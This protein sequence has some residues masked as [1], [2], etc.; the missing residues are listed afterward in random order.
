MV[1][2]DVAPRVS[3]LLPLWVLPCVVIV[4]LVVFW[5]TWRPLGGRFPSLHRDVAVLGGLLLANLLFFWRPLL[6]SAQVPR[7]GGDLNSYFFPLQAVSA[8]AIQTGQFPLWNPHLFGGMPQLA[9]YQ[10]AML[11]PPNLM[12]WMLHRPYTYGTLELLAISQYLIASVGAYFLAR[13]LGMERFPSTTAAIVFSACGFLTAHLGHYSML[14]VAVW[15]PFLFLVLRATALTDSLLWASASALVIFMAATGGHQQMLLY[16]LTAGGIWWIYWIGTRYQLWPWEGDGQ[17]FAQTVLRARAGIR[18]LAFAIS[19]AG[20]ALAVGLGLAAPMIVP[21]LQLAALSVRSGLSYEQATEFSAEPVALLQFLLPKAFG[22][23][24]TDYWGPFS[25]GEIWGYVGIVTL[26]LAAIALATRPTGVRLVLAAFAAVALL[27][28]LGPFTPLHGW[29]FRFV[30]PYNLIRAPARG[31]LF[32][33]LALALL[34][35]FG[36]SEIGYSVAQ[37]PH[38]RD[39][40]R[41]ATRGIALILGAL[42]LFVIPLFYSLILGVNDPSNRPVIAVDGL[43]L[44][45]VY[46]SGTLVLL[47]AVSRGRIRGATVVLLATVLIVLDLYGATA[48]F[49]PGS[50]DLTASYRHV[51]AVAF[52]QQQARAHGPFRIASTTLAWQPDLASIAGLDDAGGLFDP[53]QPASYKKVYD[54]MSR[55]TNP[56]LYDLLNVRYVITD[57][58]A[59]APSSSF[60]QVLKTDGGLILW[61]NQNVM[62]RAWLSYGAQQSTKAA[63]LSAVTT[64][65]FDPVSTL[66]VSGQLHPAESGGSGSARIDSYQNDRVSIHVQTDRRAYLVLADTAYP[67]WVATVDGTDT[68]IATADGIL[69]AV[70]VPAGTHEVVFRFNPPIVTVSWILSLV[71]LLILVGVATIG[72]FRRYAGRHQSSVSHARGD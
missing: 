4:W 39:V 64:P 33:D 28:A 11:Y 22:S 42:I 30:P 16:E 41:R 12:A 57:S 14:S 63:A 61:E 36:L 1:T 67:G 55:G 34:A 27:F 6:S 32:V 35:G 51:Q 13:S 18:P 29:V 58:K 2:A 47:W 44:A 69:R 68:P 71:S 5:L 59:K 8:E 3:G 48:S 7:G 52:L 31:F 45:V 65:G 70:S 54:V 23:N 37:S 10:A 62:P 60:S 21:S 40:L 66:F 43:N 20:G 25:S 19:R 38:L 49:N 15:L 46:L 56:A 72:T 53:M 17:D 24:P 9:N 26:V 50:N